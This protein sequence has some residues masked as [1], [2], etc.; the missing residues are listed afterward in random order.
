MPTMLL[1]SGNTYIG[2]VE[3]ESFQAGDWLQ[4]EARSLSVLRDET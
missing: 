2:R 1:W 4:A 3:E